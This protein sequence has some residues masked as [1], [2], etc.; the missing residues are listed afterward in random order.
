[1]SASENRLFVAKKPAFVSSNTFLQRVR[2]R[3][4]VKTAGYS[5]TLDPFAKGV[6]VMAFG[7]YTKLF[8]FLSKTP[9]KYRATLWLGAFSQTLDIEKIEDI[10]NLPPFDAKLVKQKVEELVLITSIHPPKFSAK[11]INGKKAYELARSGKEFEIMPMDITVHSAQLLTY[12]HPFVTFEVSVSEGTYVRTLGSI[13]ASKLG[14]SGS[15]TYLERICEGKFIYEN[16]IALKPLEFIDMQENYCCLS[17]E[18]I[19]N[20]KKLSIENLEKKD[21]GLYL[22]KFE[23]FFSIIQVIDNKV[24]YIL[25]GVENF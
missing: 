1:M 21:D 6:L 7:K 12:S 14:T 10:E 2:K 19:L 9:K 20:G 17:E 4:R 25:N 5:G 16:E 3:Y 8:R 18:E 15:L 13:L 22:L 11:K 24:S 23:Q